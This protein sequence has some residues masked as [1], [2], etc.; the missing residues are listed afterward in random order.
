M[1][2]IEIY[3]GLDLEAL[4]IAHREFNNLNKTDW[5]L[6]Q[7]KRSLENQ[8]YLK[9]LVFKKDNLIVGIVD[10]SVDNP[11]NKRIIDVDYALDVETEKFM[12]EYVNNFIKQN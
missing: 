11:W 4:K 9:F 5:T 12:R 6:E 2:N 10:Y 3:E 1:Q 8:E 7:F